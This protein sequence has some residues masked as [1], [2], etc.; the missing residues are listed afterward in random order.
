[1]FVVTIPPGQQKGSMM[2]ATMRCLA[3]VLLILGGFAHARQPNIIFVMADDLGYGDI[4]LYGQQDILTPSIDAIGQEGL[5][6]TRYYSGATVCAPSRSALVEGRHTGHTRVRGNVPGNNANLLDADITFGEVLKDAGYRTG[7]I[8][9]WGVGTAGGTGHPN[10]Q[11]FDYFY[12]FL[13]QGK[14]HDYYPEYIWENSEQLMLN[15]QVYIHDAFAHKALDFIQDNADGPQPFF[16]YLAYTIPHTDIEVPSTEP[17]SD[18]DWPEVEK[19][20]ASMVTRL[21]TDIGEMMTLLK[22]LGIDDDTIVFFTSDNGPHDRQGHDEEFFDSNG[23]FRGLKR[24]HYEGG[25]RVPMVVRWPGNI[26]AGGVSEQQWAAWDVLPT[27]AELGGGI[28]PGGIDGISM[29]PVLLGQTQVEQHDHLYWEFHEKGFHQAVL[30]G[31]LKAIRNDSPDNAVELYDLA[32]D[33]GETNNLAAI[34]PEVVAEMEEIMLYGREARDKWPTAIDNPP[35]RPDP[36]PD[37]DPE[38]EPAERFSLVVSNGRGSGDFP[39][40]SVVEVGANGPGPGLMFDRWIG[41]IDGFSETGKPISN[42]SMPDSD[43][44]IEPLYS[45]FPP[46]ECLEGPD[47]DG[48][49]VAD[50]CQSEVAAI[51]GSWYD[52]DRSGQGLMVHGVREDL[53]VAYFYGF[54]DKGQRLW[55]IATS[56]GPFQW[57]ETAVFDV[58]SASGGSFNDFDPG[59]VS[60]EAW[61][62]LAFRI[63]DCESSVAVLNGPPGTKRLELTRLAGVARSPCS[64]P[65][66]PRESDALTG[67]WYDAGLDGQGLAIHKVSQS[68]GIAYFY[69]FSD[70]GDRLW[71]LG[72]WEQGADFGERVEIPMLSVSGGDY[73]EY[74]PGNIVEEPWGTLVLDLKGCKVGSAVL[75]GLDGFQALDVSQLAG[76]FGME[77]P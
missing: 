7:A 11:G 54:D 40:G 53:A 20:F 43:A 27:T 70:T 73:G 46:A 31:Y 57:G 19:K 35:P 52:P 66:K 17:Y 24:D 3:L 77:C 44:A 67:S 62:S 12:G 15:G 28:A 50:D 14:A 65:M 72:V 51:T 1:M 74:D 38:P 49:G 13:D 18:R 48:N 42:Y 23:I 68:V 6:F 16:L 55:L 37:P 56:E 75:E 39:A 10:R 47:Y 29:V 9:K 4:G 5:K 41:N 64:E 30:K 8:G 45:A 71:L 69:G 63:D 61:G 2:N 22:T 26:Q 60:T 36:D 33:P 34:R 58:F 59:Q 76:S 25:I 32:V 21:D